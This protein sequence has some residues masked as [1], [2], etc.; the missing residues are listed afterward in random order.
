[1]PKNESE[2]VTQRVWTPISPREAI[3][4]RYFPEVT[5]RTQ[6]DKAVRLYDDLVKDKIVV[7]N[8][9]YATCQGICV[10]ITSN[11]VKMQSLLKERVG[12]DIF[13]LSFSLKP[14]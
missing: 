10:P 6:D 3:H 2:H 5:L 7:M 12:R 13:M 1:M 8:F 4:R 11:L 9:F 14:K